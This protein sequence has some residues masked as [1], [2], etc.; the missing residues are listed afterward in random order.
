MN[1]YLETLLILKMK[2][3]TYKQLYAD[4]AVDKDWSDPD[5]REFFIQKI[6]DLAFGVDTIERGYPMEE[7]IDR[8]EKFCEFSYKWEEHS[9][10]ES[11]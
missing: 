9:G 2:N 4:C 11:C 3:K 7:V 1:P 8:L 5:K 10:E 6:S